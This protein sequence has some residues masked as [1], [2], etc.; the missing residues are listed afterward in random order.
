MGL[1]FR[2]HVVLDGDGFGFR[3]GGYPEI[4]RPELQSLQLTPVNPIGVQGL[5]FRV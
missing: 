5:G 1:G 4:S 2:V 3:A